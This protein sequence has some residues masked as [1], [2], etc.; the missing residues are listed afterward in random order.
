MKTFFWYAS[1]SEWCRTKRCF[2]V[3]ICQ[4]KVQGNWVGL[5]LNWTDQLL[6]CSYADDVNLL[7]DNINTIHDTTDTITDAIKKHQLVP[8]SHMQ[9]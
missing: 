9:H 7:V 6:V 3:I 8:Q 2:I 4:W 5:K 1:Y